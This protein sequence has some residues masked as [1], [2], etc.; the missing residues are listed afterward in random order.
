MNIVEPI[1][2]Q[3]RSKPSELALCAPSTE[4]NL[5]SYRR[6]QRSVENICRRVIEADIIPRGRIGLMIEDP[7]FHA[8]MVIALT[9]L[10]IVTVSTSDR[11]VSW[12]ITLDAVIVDRPIESPASRTIVADAGWTAGDGR[13]LPEKHLYRAAPDDVCRVFLT[14]GNGGRQT[15]IAMTHGMIAKRLDRQK[16][17]LGPRATFCDRTHL[18]LPLATPL[19]FQVMLGTLWRGGALVMT[20]DARRTLAVLAAYNIQN[21]VATPQGLL[22]FSDAAESHPGYRSALTAVFSAGGLAAESAERVRAR[23]SSNL[24]VGY[25]ADDGTMVAAMPAQLASGISGAVGYVLPGVIVEIVDEEDRAIPLGEEGNLRI[26]SDYGVNEYLD[27]PSATQRMFRKGW[28]Y[29]GDRG[30][31]TSDRVLV[32]SN[33]VAQGA[34]VNI[35]QV[36]EILSK[37]AN[38]MQCAVLTANEFGAEELCALVVPRSYFDPEALRGYCAALLPSGLV[39]ARFVA[40]SDLPRAN[41]GKINRGKLLQLLKSGMS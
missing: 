23:L 36:E 19:G 12:P 16:L 31:L 5:V 26:R 15:A 17:L 41:D 10:G 27:N 11:N 20:W 7:I 32:L 8:L 2:L 13:P 22:E 39:P 37:H 9:R 6:L 38:V 21:I 30:R 29:P 1:F 40:L 4:F 35:E 24:T 34:A 28:F 14:S 33:R 25:V 3:C 18:D